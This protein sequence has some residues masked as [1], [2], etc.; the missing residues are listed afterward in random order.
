MLHSEEYKS[1]KGF[2]GKRAIVVGT[3][4]T[5]HDVAEDMLD[6]HLTSTTMVQRSETYVLPV[7]WY[8]KVQEQTYNAVIPT[9]LADELN[10]SNPN[11]VTRVLSMAVMHQFARNEP[12]RFEKLKQAGFNVQ[13]FG[14]PAYHLLERL[15]GHYMDVG[16]SKKIAD[17][18]VG[19]P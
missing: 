3:A 7:E 6:Y 4:N 1:P 2:E 15:G 13:V 10:S 17:G 5:A 11:A 8:V 16:C 19:L 18:L 9:A 12:E 14:D